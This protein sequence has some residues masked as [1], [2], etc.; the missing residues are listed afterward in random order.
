M[1]IHAL[2]SVVSMGLVW[3]VGWTAG[4]AGLPAAMWLLWMGPAALVAFM[5]EVSRID[6]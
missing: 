3:L 2:I 5:P 4:Q 1:A 6:I